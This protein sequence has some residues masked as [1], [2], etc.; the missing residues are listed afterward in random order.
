MKETL[1]NK[2][3]TYAIHKELCQFMCND[4]WTLLPRP[5]NVNV[6]GAK[7]I[8]KNKSD[9]FGTITRNKERLIA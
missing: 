9:K 5:N 3:L 4:V 1:T 2:H 6:I 7:W 8:F